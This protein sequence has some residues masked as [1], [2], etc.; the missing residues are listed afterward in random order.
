MSKHTNYPSLYVIG[1]PIQLNFHDSGMLK[2]AE[3]L[4]VRFTESKVRYDCAVNIGNDDWTYIYN[5]DSCFVEK[6]GQEKPN[7]FSKLEDIEKLVNNHSL[8]DES[9]KRLE[10]LFE[11]DID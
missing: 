8:I 3:I 11:N 7:Q 10:T 5:I 9:R 6:F 2:Q 1:D 4:A